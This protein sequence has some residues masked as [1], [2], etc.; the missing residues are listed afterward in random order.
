MNSPRHS[1]QFSFHRGADLSS[2]EKRKLG[3]ICAL[4]LIVA[5]VTAARA[6]NSPAPVSDQQQLVKSVFVS[7]PGPG[8]GRDVFFPRTS[9]FVSVAPVSTNPDVM[10]TPVTALT[11]KGISGPKNHRL[12]I[13]NNKTLEVGE[14]A[15]IKVMGQSF[16]VKCVEVR[17]DG[18]T[19]SVNGQVQ[20]LLLK[21]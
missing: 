9:R 11:L 20:K 1:S 19:V 8:F 5:I 18:V 7:A 17:D 14:E 10:P 4:S 2:G 3:L 15:E 21:P 12:A 6:A 13:I 16:R